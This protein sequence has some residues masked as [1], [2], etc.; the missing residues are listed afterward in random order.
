[1]NERRASLEKCNV[2]AE[3]VVARRRSKPLWEAS[4]ERTAAGRRGIGDDMCAKE[5][6]A[7]T[8]DPTRWNS[9]KLSQRKTCEG[10]FGPRRE[11][12]RFVVAMKRVMIVERRNLGSRATREEARVWRLTQV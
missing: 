9:L 5:Q 1:M 7:N 12:E 8:G 10:D 2:A 11:S 6:Y 4:E 3:P